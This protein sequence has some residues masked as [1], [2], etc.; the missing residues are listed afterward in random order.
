MKR[1]NVCLLIWVIFALGC[2]RV[3]P[4][5]FHFERNDFKRT[6]KL[7]GEKINLK[8]P[9]SIINYSIVRDSL[10]FIQTSGNVDPYFIYIYNIHTKKLL[11]SIGRKGNGPEELVSCRLSYKGSDD[12]DLYVSDIVKG[13]VFIYN[14]DSVI[15]N[16]DTYVPNKV[17]IPNYFFDGVDF[18]LN[19]MICY[20]LYY[21]DNIKYNNNIPPVFFLNKKNGVTFPAM[22]EGNKNFTFNVSGGEVIKEPN[23]NNIWVFHRQMNRIDIFD[24]RLNLIRS[25]EGPGVYQVHYKKND[26]GMIVHKDHRIFMAYM[27]AFAMKDA[28]YAAYLDMNGISV[29]E[30]EPKPVEIFKFSWTGDLLCRYQLDQCAFYFTIDRHGKYLYASA[31]H[32]NFAESAELYRYKL[33]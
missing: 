2:T 21:I 9:I 28:V 30:F 10:V 24:Q 14:V 31:Q 12:H 3:E 11:A 20:N 1:Y 33:R 7:I 23:H 19:N 13:E 16:H 5:C 29:K 6:V 22:K 17:K 26:M 25:I 27:Y 4:K 8:G 15:E 18:G 32:Q